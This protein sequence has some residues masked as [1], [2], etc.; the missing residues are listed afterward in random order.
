MTPNVNDHLPYYHEGAP[1]TFFQLLE[2]HR[3]Y[4]PSVER[5]GDRLLCYIEVDG[6]RFGIALDIGNDTGAMVNLEETLALHFHSSIR[7]TLKRLHEAP[8]APP[9]AQTD[10]L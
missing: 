7:R 8:G 10:P 1:V 2:Y 9:E 4:R 3:T 6:Q 5:H